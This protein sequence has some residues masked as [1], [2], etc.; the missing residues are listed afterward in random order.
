MIATLFCA[1][2]ERECLTETV[3]RRF[4]LSA[5]RVSPEIQFPLELERAHGLTYNSELVVTAVEAGSPAQEAGVTTGFVIRRVGGTRVYT[6]TE[7][8][9]PLPALRSSSPSSWSARTG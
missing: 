7:T 9:Q 8:D 5:D 4:Q 3:L 1:A 6:K 2:C